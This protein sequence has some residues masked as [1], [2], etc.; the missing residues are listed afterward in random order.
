MGLLGFV[1]KD[2][3][4]RA[5]VWGWV[6]MGTLEVCGGFLDS[7]FYNDFCSSKLWQAMLISVYV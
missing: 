2:G 6:A 4:G 3:W 7:M 5:V 1:L